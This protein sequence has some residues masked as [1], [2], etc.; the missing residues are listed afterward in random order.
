MW[1]NHLELD[2]HPESRPKVLAL[3][4]HSHG[5]SQERPWA[6]ASLTACSQTPDTPKAQEIKC[7]VVLRHLIARGRTNVLSSDRVVWR[8]SHWIYRSLFPSWTELEKTNKQT[9]MQSTGLLRDITESSSSPTWNNLSEFLFV[10]YIGPAFE[11]CV[12]L[13]IYSQILPVTQKWKWKIF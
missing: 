7:A 5:K 13:V 9:K 6:V 4:I 8:Y 10:D 2:L 11:T 12:G 3:T 1:M